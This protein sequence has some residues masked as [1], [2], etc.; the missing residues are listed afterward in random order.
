MRMDS[1]AYPIDEANLPEWFKELPFDDAAME[2]AIIDQKV[3]NLV[4]VLQWDLT[5]TRVSNAD[6]DEFFT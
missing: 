1:V 6:L 3:L 5:N 4:G 2:N